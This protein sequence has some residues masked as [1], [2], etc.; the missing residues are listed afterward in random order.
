MEKTY[1]KLAL[2]LGACLGLAL[3]ILLSNRG[4]QWGGWG[5]RSH[6]AAVTLLDAPVTAA[7]QVTGDTRPR[8]LIL[9]SPGY[10]A[11]VK[12]EKNLRIALGHLRI[13]ADSL[14]LGRTEAVRYTDYDLVILASAY[15]ETEMTESAARLLR[16]VAQGGRLLVGTVPESLGPQFELSY[17]S[18]GIADYGDYL[19]YDTIAFCG[20]VVPGV[21]GRT[22]T[23]ESLSDVMLSATL[24]DDAVVYAWGQD[25][26]GR[27]S[28]LIWRYDCGLGRVAVFNC[29]S[30]SGDFWRGMAAGC[31]N[32]LFDTTLYPIINA[33]CLFIDD[34]PSPQYESE[35]DVVREEYNRSA[36]EFYRDI[37]W[38]DMLQ[39]AKAY[40][41]V[42]TG[43][44]V[45]TYNSEVDPAKLTYT[46]SATQQYFGVSLLKNG[47]ELGAHGYNHQPLTLQ[48]GTPA[49][50]D[51]HGWAGQQEMADSLRRLGEIA[52]QLFPGVALRCYVPPSNYLSAEGRQAVAAA[53]P[54][55]S[56]ISGIYTNEEEEGDVYVQDFSVAQDGIVEFPR[57]TAGMAPDDFE[58]LS[59]YSAVGLYG[60]FSHFI[61]PDDI[62]DLERGKGQNWEQLY[63]SYCAWMQ[64]IHEA[65]PFL[66]SLTAT[67]AADA[68]R[69]AETAQ[70]HL[71]IEADEIRGSIEGFCGDTCF[72]LR[73]ERTPR[74]VDD[75]CTIRRVTAGSGEGYYLLT[76]KSPNFTVKLV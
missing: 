43:L 16:Y 14:E 54:D 32:L 42:Y 19:P 3:L 33:L 56:V 15:W 46:P 72:F 64:D 8:A 27:Q 26:Q 35:S 69:I 20:D 51:Y 70:P 50:M 29:T 2:L 24:E 28:P 40:G 1:R 55:L 22:F 73:T 25:G 74:A 47:C 58:Q 38:P 68:V 61:H 10:E 53:L 52:A 49:D 6:P 76:V 41:D 7:L 65:Y 13:R 37:W 12:Y 62:F 18:F 34:F 75:N 39:V 31:V 57:I 36:R 48:G 63:R 60:V 11:S 66:R 45:A 5:K 17:R 67:E 71:E 9:Y 21:T 44:F 23:G 30:G 59:A 4:V